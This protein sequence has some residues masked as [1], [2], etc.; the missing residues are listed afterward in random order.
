M[1]HDHHHGEVPAARLIARAIVGAALLLLAACGAPSD[2]PTGQD[3]GSDGPAATSTETASV[4]LASADLWLAFEDSE[5]SSEGTTEFPDAVGG[6]VVARVVSANGGRVEIVEGVGGTGSAIAFPPLCTGDAGCPRAMVEVESDPALEPG[7]DPFA[8]G[9]T[10]WLAP[11]DTTT[12]SN[13]VQKG[14]FATDGGL[15]KLQVDDEEGH[16][17]CVLR[18]GDTLLRVR[19]EVTV[20]DSSWHRV[21]CSRDA[22]GISIDVDGVEDREDGTLGSVDS[23]WP[24]RVGSPGVGDDDDQFHGRVDDVFLRLLPPT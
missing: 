8:F 13:I 10:V 9:A 12:G 17:S 11:E 2:G 23:E 15:W 6:D 14:R 1:L 22:D 16:P 20:A 3:G 5:A 7:E 4:D 19:S 24:I 21:V 18:S